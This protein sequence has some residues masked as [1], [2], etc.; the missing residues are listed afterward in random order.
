MITPNELKEFKKIIAEDY[1]YHF[2]DDKEALKAA[3]NLLVCFE[4]VLKPSKAKREK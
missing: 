4:A 3:E 2:C 1:D